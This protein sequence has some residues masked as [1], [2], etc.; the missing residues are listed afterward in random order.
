[1]VEAGTFRE[2]LFYRLNGMTIF[3]PPLREREADIPLLVEYFLS[4]ACF[5]MNRSN[6]E[7]V[8]PEALALLTSYS[9]PGNVRELRSVVRQALLN[10][11]GPVIVPEFLPDTVKN[12]K[13]QAAAPAAERPAS[14][15]TDPRLP[16]SDLAP[17][18][19]LRLAN[20]S[21]RLYAESLEM[22]ERY[23]FTR[24]LTETGGNQ[25]RAAEILGVTR[26]KIRDRIAQFGISLD[27]IVS[28]ADDDD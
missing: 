9:W 8:S 16:N 25:S 28:L 17:F 13:L 3:L 15:G 1:M 2:D 10:C 14:G 27:Q 21:T 22:M 24:V 6:F 26:G 12:G 7:G 18:V 5:E 23:L 4:D 20:D 11:T 19:D